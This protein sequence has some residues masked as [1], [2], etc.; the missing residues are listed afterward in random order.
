MIGDRRK[1][2]TALIGIELDTVSD[3]AGRRGGDLHDLRRPC[4]EGTGARA[5]RE[6]VEQVNDELA[7]VEQVKR[8]RLL[9]KELDH[10]D[11]QLTATQKVKR[12]GDLGR[13]RG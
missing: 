13:V 11:G 9:R 3:W 1:Y 4:V 2:V 6:W 8:F 10:E 12:A 7:Q 5:H